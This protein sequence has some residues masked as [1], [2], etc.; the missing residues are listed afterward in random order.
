MPKQLPI[1]RLT[2]SAARLWA[3]SLTQQEG[4]TYAS[5][6]RRSG[7]REYQTFEDARQL[8]L[9]LGFFVIR[10]GR[11]CPM[12]TPPEEFERKPLATMPYTGVIKVTNAK[13]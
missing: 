13:Q 8:L 12:L 9:E 2:P 10:D 11:E 3:A 5:I 6:V 4:E 7:I 1:H